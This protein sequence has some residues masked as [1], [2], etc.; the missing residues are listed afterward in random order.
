MYE[1]LFA[2][3]GDAFWCFAPD[4]PGFGGTPAPPE[5]AT[6][7][8]YADALHEALKAVGIERCWM[9]GHHTGASIAVQMLEDHPELALKLVLSGPP[10]LSPEQQEERIAAVQPPVLAKD[11]S[12]LSEVWERTLAKEPDMPLALAHREAVLNLHAGERWH[13][14]YLAVFSHDLAGQLPQVLCPM[15]LIAGEWDKLLPCLDAAIE[16]VPAARRIVVPGVGSLMCD[17]KVKEVAQALRD[18]LVVNR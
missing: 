18:F 15:L 7:K 1:P 10:F 17:L 4:T 9:F 13:E 16:A 6:V 2:E 12:H 3:L 5:T 14:A 8:Y 11:G